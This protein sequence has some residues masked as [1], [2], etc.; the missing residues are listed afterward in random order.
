MI[1]SDIMPE[2][3]N[4]NLSEANG[5]ENKPKP[6]TRR[7]APEKPAENTGENKDGAEDKTPNENIGAEGAAE[8]TDQTPE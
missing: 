6:R 7:K 1:G 8:S 4:E 5:A 2:E 3:K